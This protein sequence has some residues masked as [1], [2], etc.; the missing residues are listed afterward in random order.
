MSLSVDFLLGKI[1][2]RP[3]PL[4]RANGFAVFRSCGRHSEG[5]LVVR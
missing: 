3:E 2:K 5:K 1:A 4:Y